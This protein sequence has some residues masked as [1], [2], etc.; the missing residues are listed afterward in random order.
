LAPVAVGSPYQSLAWASA[1]YRHAAPARGETPFIVA[2]LDVD[3]APLALLPFAL[4]R[5]PL[6][7]V[8]VSVGGSHANFQFGPFRRDA[9]EILSA[10]ALTAALQIAARGVGCDAYLLSQQATEWGGATNPL[11]RL[12]GIPCVERGRSAALSPDGEAWFTARFSADRRRTL[13]KK[14]RGLQALGAARYIEARTGAD[15]DRMIDAY[16]AQ[17]ADWFARRGIANVFTAPGIDAFLRDAAKGGLAEGR[18]GV[19]LFA[20]EVDDRLAAVIGAAID[21]TRLSLMIT[22]ADVDSFGRFS[23]GEL[24]LLHLMKQSCDRGLATFDLGVGDAAYKEHY[25]PDEVL[26]FD[27]ALP[28]TAR[29]RLAAGA[30]LGRRAMLAKAKR[31]PSVLGLVRRVRQARARL[32]PTTAA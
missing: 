4:R 2:L 5:T 30:W 14:E 3:G 20:L 24:L 31:S 23:P 17:K 18:P 32:R 29:G 10:E 9:L 28:M 1:W 26:L 19:S 22:A 16:Q 27:L 12:G 25:C 15:V 8:A 13:R 6:G 21:D 11:Q 7:R